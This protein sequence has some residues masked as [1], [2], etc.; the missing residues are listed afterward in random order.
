[1]NW[2]VKLIKAR[3][4]EKVIQ[5]FDLLIKIVIAL[6]KKYRKK[7]DIENKF[8]TCNQHLALMV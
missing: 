1:M 5:D 8:K 3:T 6:K 7:R 4:H 2:Q